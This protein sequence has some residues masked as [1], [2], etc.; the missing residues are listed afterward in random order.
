M[1]TL[2]EEE[3]TTTPSRAGGSVR[4][5]YTKRKSA[6]SIQGTVGKAER[7]AQGMKELKEQ[8]ARERRQGQVAGPSHR[9]AVSFNATHEMACFPGKSAGCSSG[10]S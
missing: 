6:K 8:G 1:V 3:E 7:R 4:H 5:E 2:M 9:E 10:Q